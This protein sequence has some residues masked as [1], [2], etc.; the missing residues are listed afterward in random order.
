[1]ARDEL[2]PL[3]HQL[4]RLAADTK[5]GV[6]LLTLTRALGGADRGA[7]PAKDVLT[8]SRIV[9]DADPAPQPAARPE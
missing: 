1:M 7:A 2:P 6:E 4:Q 5:K 9:L 3:I 8:G